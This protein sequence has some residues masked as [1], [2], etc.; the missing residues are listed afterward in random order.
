MPKVDIIVPAYNAARY[1]PAA[2]ESVIAQTFANWRILLVDHGST[3]NTP[4]VLAPFIDSLGPSQ[5]H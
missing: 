4:E 2:I 3:D 5:V 1:L